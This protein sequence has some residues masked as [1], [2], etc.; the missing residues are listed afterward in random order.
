MM[1]PLVLKVRVQS[2]V[3]LE[4]V[5]V[6][7]AEGEDVAEEACVVSSKCNLELTC[8]GKKKITAKYI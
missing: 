1:T 4:G 5:V 6:G 7:E 3:A 2:E 8:W